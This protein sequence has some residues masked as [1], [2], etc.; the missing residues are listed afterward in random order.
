MGRLLAWWRAWISALLGGRQTHRIVRGEP[1]PPAVVPGLPPPP[2]RM[3]APR[4][5]QTRESGAAH[6]AGAATGAGRGELPDA[7]PRHGRRGW[8]RHRRRCRPSSPHGGPSS[9]RIGASPRLTGQ[10]LSLDSPAG[11]R[12]NG[13]AAFPDVAWQLGTLLRL[14]DPPLS[15]VKLVREPARPAGLDASLLG[16]HAR[17]PNSLDHARAIGF[18]ALWRIGM[19]APVLGGL[20]RT[21]FPGRR[22]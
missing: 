5:V 20:S 7:P 19:S 8:H 18:D 14:G 1:R 4:T 16:F 2:G 17:P 3:P 10:H 15:G 21:G 22:R 9:T 6:A 11:Y 12:S 13:L